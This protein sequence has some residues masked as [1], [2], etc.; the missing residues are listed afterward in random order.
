MAVEGGKKE[1]R[2]S[3]LKFSPEAVGW[4]G[5]LSDATIIFS[6]GSDHV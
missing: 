1:E 2:A 5:E 6:V 4:D 3:E